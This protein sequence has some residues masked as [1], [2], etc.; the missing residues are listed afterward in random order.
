MHQHNTYSDFESALL[1]PYSADKS[2]IQDGV[3]V[4]AKQNGTQTFDEGAFDELPTS[5]SPTKESHPQGLDE[6]ARNQA[7]SSAELKMSRTWGEDEEN[8]S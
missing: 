5:T 7:I 1:L 8:V 3:P 6:H 4:P 2:T